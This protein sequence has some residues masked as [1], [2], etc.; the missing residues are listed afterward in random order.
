MNR[1][2]PIPSTGSN[3][4]GASEHSAD[5]EDY[6]YKVGDSSNETFYSCGSQA[7]SQASSQ[8][9]LTSSK[10]DEM[11]FSPISSVIDGEL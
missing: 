5:T 9:S 2:T 3:N 7:P 10:V 8:S 1:V 6:S 4:P 11:A